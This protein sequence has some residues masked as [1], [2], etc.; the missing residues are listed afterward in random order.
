MEIL[1][2]LVYELIAQ[3]VD[4]SFIVQ[5]ERNPDSNPTLKFFDPRGNNPDTCM[6]ASGSSVIKIV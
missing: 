3:I 1:S 2:F 4:L 6:S 5:C